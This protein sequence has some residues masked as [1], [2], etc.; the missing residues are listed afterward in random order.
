MSVQTDTL[1]LSRID[2]EHLPHYRKRTGK[3]YSAACPFCGLGDDRFRY[4]PDKG[5]YWCRRCDTRGFVIEANTLHF[6]PEQYD[7]WKRAEAERQQK[8]HLKQRE[9]IGRLSIARA[10]F[11]HVQMVDRS[12]WY[13]QGL[14]DETINRFKLGYAPACPTYPDSPGWTIPIFYQGKLYNIRHRLARPNGSGKYRPEIAGLPAAVFNA[15]V[16]DS[17][18]WMVVLVEGEIKAMCLQQYGF[19][20]VG[21]PGAN[22]FKDRWLKLFKPDSAVYVALDPGA[23][24]QAREIATALKASGIEARVCALPCKPDDMLCKYGGSP[25]DLVKFLA[26]GKKV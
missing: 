26:L 1:Q 25:A 21:I 8:E 16:L 10:E 17:G 7:A 22:S 19:S 23:E 18:D 4:W 3:E 5:N 15:D 14:N 6:S 24:E 12:Y 20:A 13:E 11:Y 2:I 9:T